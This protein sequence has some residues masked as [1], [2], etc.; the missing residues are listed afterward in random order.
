MKEGRT[1]QSIFSFEVMASF[2]SPHVSDRDCAAK[3]Q[4]GMNYDPLGCCTDVKLRLSSL[5]HKSISL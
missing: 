2:L 1:E 4:L 5:P 3:A